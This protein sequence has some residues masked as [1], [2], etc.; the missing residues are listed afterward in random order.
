MTI[1]VSVQKMCGKW[2]EA[3]ARAEDEG[4]HVADGVAY[5]EEGVPLEEL[6]QEALS[7]LEAVMALSEQG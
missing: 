3:L 2:T 1:T 4:G 6:V 5:G 7:K